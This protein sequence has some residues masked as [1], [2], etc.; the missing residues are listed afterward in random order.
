[1]DDY[2]KQFIRNNCIVFDQLVSI[3]KEVYPEI[4]PDPNFTYAQLQYNGGRQAVIRFIEQHV[5]EAMADNILNQHVF[6]S[7]NNTG[8]SASPNA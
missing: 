7:P 5:K 4:N 2:N 6:T 8:T 1:M 3:L